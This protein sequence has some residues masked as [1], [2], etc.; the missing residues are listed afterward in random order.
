[1]NELGSK[2]LVTSPLTEAAD[3]SSSP[4]SL[5]VEPASSAAAT[6]TSLAEPAILDDAGSP[7]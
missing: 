5:I 6:S 3:T 1:L 7:V 2:E 4:M